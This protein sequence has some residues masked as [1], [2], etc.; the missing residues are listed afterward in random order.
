MDALDQ[1]KGRRIQRLQ[2]YKQ[3]VAQLKS[4]AFM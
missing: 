2:W 1:Q 3:Q 4:S